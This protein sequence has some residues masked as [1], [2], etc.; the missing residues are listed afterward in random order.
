MW[1][2][3]EIG[4]AV[5]FPHQSIERDFE[6]VAHHPLKEAYFL[7][8]PP[9]HDRPTWDPTATLQ[10]VLPDEAYFELSPAGSVAIDDH[11]A[12]AFKAD[13]SGLDRYLILP[14]NR[15]DRVR[16]AIVLLSSEPQP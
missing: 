5:T 9:P 4:I 1:S 2:G 11:G 12:C 16:E 7:Y 13:E 15:A 10:A 14:P 6:Y 8:E 3:F